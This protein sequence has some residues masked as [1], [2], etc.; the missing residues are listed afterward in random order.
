MYFRATRE[1]EMEAHTVQPLP[2]AA[3]WKVGLETPVRIT[4]RALSPACVPGPT[5]GCLDA[6][7]CLIAHITSRHPFY[8]RRHGGSERPTW[9]KARSKHSKVRS[10]PRTHVVRARRGVGQI[11]PKPQQAQSTHCVHSLTPTMAL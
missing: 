4:S 11:L 7:D 1:E 9:D 6:R 2:E 10:F 3:G 8:R 5:H